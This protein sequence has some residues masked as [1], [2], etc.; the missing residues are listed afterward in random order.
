MLRKMR[1]RMMMLRRGKVMRLRVMMWRNDPKTASHNLY[2][3]VQSKCTRASHK[4]HF[5][6]N[7]QEKGYTPQRLASR[8][9]RACAVEIQMDMPEQPFYPRIHLKKEMSRPRVWLHIVRKP[10]QS[11]C[12]M[13][14]S[15]QPFYARN[16]GKN[17]APQK[18]GARFARGFRNCPPEKL[19]HPSSR[20]RFVLQNTACRA[21]AT[22]TH[23]ARDFP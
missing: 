2:E 8:C 3:P 10:A 21:S 1:W 18:L 7:L 23:V 5:I 4:S 6:R 16:Y 13:D 11:K 17:R 15:E 22:K 20:T 9:A 14:M 19:P 12:N